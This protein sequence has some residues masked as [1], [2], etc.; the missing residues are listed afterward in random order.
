[1]I[2]PRPLRTAIEHTIEVP[3]TARYYTIGDASGALEE[4]WFVLHGLGQ[5]AGQ[6]AHYF[7]DMANGRRLVL[8]PEALTRY[9][10]ASTSV[11]ASERPVAATWMTREVFLNKIRDSARY[12]TLPQHDVVPN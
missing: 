2:D 3:R 11:P 5:L 4:M 1:M 6:F 12:L 10:T 7:A 9:Y 8:A